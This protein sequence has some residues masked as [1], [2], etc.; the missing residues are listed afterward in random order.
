MKKLFM[1]VAACAV[2]ASCN[3]TGKN[4][5]VENPQDSVMAVDTTA[6]AAGVT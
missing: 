5:K 4:A 6:A 1:M 2:I 3:Q